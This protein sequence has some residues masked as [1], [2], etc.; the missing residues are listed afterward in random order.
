MSLIIWGDK[1]AAT[2]LQ[3]EA[4]SVQWHKAYNGSGEESH[5]HYVIETKDGGFVMVGETGFTEDRSAKIF[6]VATDSLGNLKW[7]REI[8]EPGYNLGNCVCETPNGHLIVA[9]SL[10]QDAAL[11]KLN[12]STGAVLWIK[13]WDLGTED[14]FE[15]I[16][17]ASD[18]KILAV[19]YINGL[20]EGSFL[21]WG[22]GIMLKTDSD[23]NQ[24]WKRDLSSHISAGYRVKIIND[25][26][27]VSG[28]PHTEGKK[29]FNLLKMDLSGRIVW[30]RTYNTIYWGFDIDKQGNLIQAGHTTKSP[31]SNNWDIELTKVNAR[32]EK[33]WTKFFGQPRGY[34]PRWIHD[35]VWGARA[36]PDGGWLAVAG[37]GDETSR[38]EGKGHPSGNSGQWKIYLIKTDSSG[39][40]DWQGI[41]GTSRGDWAGEDVCLTQDG[42]ALVANDCGKFGFTKIS[43][44]GK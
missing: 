36:T 34:N 11:V 41:Y 3:K 4:P 14:V 9:G 5:P 44:F 20:A 26:Y 13:K 37:T 21:N 30:A 40:L 6:V 29:D 18:G 7:Q 8:G 1:T 23:G 32:G 33:I 2:P 24:I 38:Y 39:N 15:G 22:Q 10:N 28:H 27:V 12:H 25:G 16:D 17:I 31:L 35:E 42:G 19:G 43:P